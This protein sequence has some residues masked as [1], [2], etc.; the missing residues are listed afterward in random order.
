[1]VISYLEKLQSE[2]MQEKFN[3]EKELSALQIHLRENIEF[4][5]T[6]ECN[7]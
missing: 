4:G 1:M 3:A 5:R 7:R 2:Y 6:D